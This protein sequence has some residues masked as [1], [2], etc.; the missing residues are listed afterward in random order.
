M[1]D[2]KLSDFDRWYKP[3]ERCGYDPGKSTINRCWACGRRVDRDYS[4]R[5]L[6]KKLGSW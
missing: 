2:R 3:C 5:A 6:K 1:V 4:D